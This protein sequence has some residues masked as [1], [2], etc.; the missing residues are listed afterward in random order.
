MRIKI[1]DNKNKKIIGKMKD[2]M[3]G[4]VVSEFTGLKSKMYSSIRVD[5]EGKIRAKGVNK[6]LKYN[7][8][9]DVL[10]NKKVIRHNYEKNSS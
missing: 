7:E 1:Y 4:K 3:N 8:F 10:F 5:N 6:K 9:C 2:K